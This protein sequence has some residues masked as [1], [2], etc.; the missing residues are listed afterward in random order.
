V[1]PQSIGAVETALEGLRAR[2]PALKILLAAEA[3][4]GSSH[5]EE[6][7]RDFQHPLADALVQPYYLR[8]IQRIVAAVLAAWEERRSLDPIAGLWVH[9]EPGRWRFTAPVVHRAEDLHAIGIPDR[10]ILG[11]FRGRYRFS[12]IGRM[13]HVFYSYGCR[14]KCRYCPMS[15]SDGSMFSRPIADVVAELESL[16]EPHV[17]LQDFEPFLLPAAM[18]ELADAVERAGIRKSWYMLT[19]ADTALAQKDL[20]VR[21][22]RLGLRWLYLG[23]DGES[24]QRLKEIK[25]S[26]TVETNERALR[27]MRALGLCVVVGFVVRSDYTKEDFAAL[28]A[29]VKRLPAPL[30]GFTVE[31]PLVG[32]K[33]FDESESRLSTRD[34]SLFDL[35]HAVLP[36]AMPLDDFYRELTRLRVAL[37]MRGLPAMLRHFPLRDFARIAASGP[38]TILESLRTARD[39]EVTGGPGPEPAT[40]PLPELAPTRVIA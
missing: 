23:L 4:Y 2:F 37:G 12:G 19:R 21:W 5:V 18:E 7:P 26:S 25:K 35:G 6:R 13:A 9:D 15:K 10:T 3:E 32:T 28:R 1:N 34:W 8:H 17:Y 29:Y 30:V 20:I 14:F 40:Q 11:K 27:E 33:L 36:T 39:H 16:T 22:K 24:P 38:S 31:T